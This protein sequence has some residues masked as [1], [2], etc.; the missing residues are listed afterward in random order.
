MLILI[1]LEWS[2]LL[3]IYFSPLFIY[4]VISCI[5][6]FSLIFLV[7]KKGYGSGCGSSIEC[8]TTK[9]LLCPNYPGSCNCP[10][11]SNAYMCDCYGNSYYDFNLNRCGIKLILN[12]GSGIVRSMKNYYIFKFHCY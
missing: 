6:D 4:I 7:L 11:T 1:L 10:Y 3:L 5:L 8:D 12:L 2:Y 9:G